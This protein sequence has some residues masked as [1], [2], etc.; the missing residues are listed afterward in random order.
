MMVCVWTKIRLAL[1]MKLF[2]T[3]VLICDSQV[4]G[5]V[6]TCLKEKRHSEVEYTI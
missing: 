1:V 5:L 3:H 2:L 6:R 4:V